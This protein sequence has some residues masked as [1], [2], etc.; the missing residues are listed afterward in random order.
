MPEMHGSIKSLVHKLFE[1]CAAR[2]P[3]RVAL[4]LGDSSLTYAGLADRSTMIAAQ[5]RKYGV[6]KG[7]LVGVFL[8]RSFDLIATFIAILKADA[9]YVPIDTNYPADRLDF[10]VRDTGMKVILTLGSLTERLPNCP[11]P[12]LD[13]HQLSGGSPPA[14]DQAREDALLS[15]EDAAYVM[16]TSG[17][18]GI[19]K[20]VVVP[21]RG[22]ARLVQQPDF[23]NIFAN[24]VF[25][26]V[27]PVSFDASTLEIWGAL[28]N[29]ARL[30]LM[31]PGQPSLEQIGE[32]IRR[33]SVSILWLTAGLFNLMVDERLEDLSP[34]K[35][36]LA[37][38]DVLSVPHIRRALA[39]LP[40]TQIINGYGPTENTTFTCCYQIPRDLPETGSV[41][42]GHPIR[43]TTIHIVDE[44]F[45]EVADG[46][47]GELVTGGLG[48]ALGY[49]NRPEL[50]TE[51]FITA[52]FAGDPNERFYRTGDHVRRRSDGA[53]EFLGRK[54][55][56][57]KLRGF[58]IELGEIESA[59]RQHAGV[60]DC[61]VAVR[62][63]PSGNRSLSA[64][65]VPN[66]KDRTPSPEDVRTFAATRL[67]DHMIPAFWMWLEE[68]PLNANGKV[69]RARLPDP[70][71]QEQII[72]REPP[73]NDM[74][75]LLVELWQELLGGRVVGVT[76]SY[77]EVG[78]NSLLVAQAHERLRRKH[79]FN[80]Q[81]PDM[82]RFATVRSLSDHLQGIQ[83]RSEEPPR[84]GP[85][86]AV[87]RAGALSRFKRK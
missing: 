82:F 77:F 3:G 37:G 50:T 31:P 48:L 18:T 46:E 32:V 14:A 17:S 22:I 49:W 13:L 44:H 4:T 9:A 59:L 21:H 34:V 66:Q 1:R 74:E 6:G 16:Y 57:V 30:A 60:R 43:G 51:R 2:S 19:P 54:D 36:L 78:A 28:T 20:G 71:T 61:A 33:E 64:W 25:L 29:G 81:L 67:P 38:G 10:M 58:R 11:V 86:R 5:L 79:G 70:L 63:D 80:L 65:L 75:K 53:L 56:Q 27:S 12:V 87:L 84:S 7:D 23:V 55:N 52:K 72:P 41:P 8:D 24:D 83:N 85:D 69:D 40:N 26:Q 15:G 47:E 39:K 42:I 35:Q 45:R 68:L 76:D 73:R 62:A